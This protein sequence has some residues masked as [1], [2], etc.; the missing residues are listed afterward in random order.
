MRHTI[1][2]CIA[3]L[4]AALALSA[5]AAAPG[6]ARHGGAAATAPAPA[7]LPTVEFTEYQLANG[8]RVILAPTD[9]APVVAVC[10]TYNVGSFVEPPGRSGFAHLFEHLM[11]QGSKNLPKGAFDAVVVNS[12]GDDNGETWPD[13]TAFYMVM[14]ANRLEAAL[15]VHADT[16]EHLN[17]DQ[18]NLDNQRT[19][20]QEE[21]R[22]DV[23]NKPYGRLYETLLDHAYT[24]FAYRHPPIGSMADIDKAD[25]DDV[26][27]FYETYYAPNNAVLSIVGDFDGRDARAWVAQHFGPIPTGPDPV[28]P[29]LDEPP[30]TSEKRVKLDDPLAPFPAYAAAY[31]IPSGDHADFAALDMLSV[32][33]AGGKSARPWREVVEKRQLATSVR[34]DAEPRRGPGLFTVNLE[35]GPGQSVEAAERALEAEIARIRKDGVTESEVGTARVQR[36]RN[37][38][39]AR[40]SAL[41]RAIALGA[42][43]VMFGDAGRINTYQERFQNVTPEDVRRVAR[44]YLRPENRTVV[45][46]TPAPV[47]DAA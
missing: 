47:G 34:A 15:Y 39:A 19:V 9:A 42:N 3:I 45:V 7:V 2:I 10:V 27:W 28:M 32:I 20:V 1:Y 31:R 25:L 44:A 35:F 17:V 5:R 12:G 23:E 38:L 26:T 13:R 16:M 24:N 14:P 40:R 22:R 37:V 18:E 29:S 8:L 46:A 4:A 33:L 6:A 11:F 43:A 41:E 30:Q 21:R 36:R